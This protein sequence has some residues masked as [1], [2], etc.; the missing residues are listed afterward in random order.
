MLVCISA[1]VLFWICEIADALLT[2]PTR[3][4]R[5]AAKREREAEQRRSSTRDS[6]S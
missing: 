2:D 1:L 4:L 6:E 5:R 3:A